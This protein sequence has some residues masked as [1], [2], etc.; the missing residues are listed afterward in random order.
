V[1][2]NGIFQNFRV[3]LR[4]IPSN[5]TQITFEKEFIDMLLIHG[6]EFKFRVQAIWYIENSG[7]MNENY[8][9]SER[10]NYIYENNELVKKDF[11]PKKD[12]VVIP[13]M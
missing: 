11:V 7:V 13:L 9:H 5:L 12:V 6:N 8:S 2:K 4:Q 3:R 10:V 1:F